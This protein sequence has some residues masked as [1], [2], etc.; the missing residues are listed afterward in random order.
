MSCFSKD[1]YGRQ[2]R[3]EEP[4]EE[5]C[6]KRKEVDGKKEADTAWTHVHARAAA[7]IIRSIYLMP[8]HSA[9]LYRSSATS[10][11]SCESKLLRA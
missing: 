4:E 11:E 3:K 10:R 8:F 7:S 5:E 9:K 2:K 1:E 6:G